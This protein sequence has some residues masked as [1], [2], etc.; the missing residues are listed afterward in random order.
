MTTHVFYALILH[1][2]IPTAMGP[3]IKRPQNNFARAA[4]IIAIY[5]ALIIVPLITRTNWLII[6][7]TAIVIIVTNIIMMIFIKNAFV[8]RTI[9]LILNVLLTVGIFGNPIWFAGFNGTVA[10]LA[11]WTTNVNALANTITTADMHS[12]LVTTAGLVLVSVEINHPI[13][14]V[15]KHTRLMPEVPAGNDQPEEVLGKPD[16]A[17]RGRVIGYLE[18]AVVFI[19]TITGNLSALGLVLVAKG[20]ARFSQ[21]NDRDFAEYFLIGTLLS[22]ALAIGLGF[23]ASRFILLDA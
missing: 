13:A 18:R 11:D 23:L 14:L 21:L 7:I 8:S 2:L 4:V 6:M 16:E 12:I 3:S 15:L 19:L 10:R 17:A 9:L 5:V 22:V 1:L 20:L